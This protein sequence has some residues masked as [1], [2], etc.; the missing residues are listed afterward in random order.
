MNWLGAG[1]LIL[2]ALIGL[3]LLVAPALRHRSPAVLI[4]WIA[5]AVAGALGMWS[6][7]WPS[8]P[9]VLWLVLGL[10]AGLGNYFLFATEVPVD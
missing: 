8:S 6:I 2:A 7:A 10:A 3:A 9:V 1:L 4:G 5:A